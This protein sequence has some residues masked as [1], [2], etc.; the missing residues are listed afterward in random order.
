MLNLKDAADLA[1]ARELAAAA[2]VLVENNRPGVMERIGLGYAELSAANPGLVYCAISGYGQ[3]GPSALNAAYAP[4]IHAS[5]GYDLA[6]LGYQVGQDT[7]AS[8]AIFLADVVGA[9]YACVAVEAALLR[10]TRT[11]CGEYIDVSMFDGM[12]ALMVYEMQVAQLAEPAIRSIYR[13]MPTTDGFVSV[14][15]VNVKQVT[16]LLPVIGREDW[17]QDPRWLDTEQ[18]ELHWDELMAA[19]AA[20]TARRDTAECLKLLAEVGVAAAPYRTPAEALADPQ[21]RQRGVL[22][23]RRD[24][25]GEHYLFNPPFQFADGSVHVRGD[26]PGLGADRTAVLRDWLGGAPVDD[27]PERD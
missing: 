21:V 6:N 19:V 17:L 16:A 20:W 27:Q 22:H 15:P 12:L 4:N 14:A 8:T 26:A 18:R 9:L 23:P 11:G 10:R 5:S 7:P 3:T 13:P 25:G 24:A 2:D 1:T